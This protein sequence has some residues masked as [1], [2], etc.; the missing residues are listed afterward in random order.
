M[1]DEEKKQ[2]INEWLSNPLTVALFDRSMPGPYGK[3]AY[4]LRDDFLSEQLGGDFKVF[5]TVPFAADLIDEL[6][7]RLR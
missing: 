5:Q 4:W 6:K 3:A 1:T 2:V 7:L